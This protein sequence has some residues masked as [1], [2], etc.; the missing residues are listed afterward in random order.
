MAV[1]DYL[2]SPLTF[3]PRWAWCLGTED[4]VSKC[5]RDDNGKFLFAGIQNFGTDPFTGK[6]VFFRR[7]QRHG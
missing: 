2:P 1:V 6:L 3:P 4:K 5:P 7:L